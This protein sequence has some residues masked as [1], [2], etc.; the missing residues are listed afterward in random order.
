MPVRFGESL[1]SVVLQVWDTRVKA[2]VHNF[3]NTYQVTAVCF[4]D[5][6]EHVFSGGIDNDIKVWD[7]RMGASFHICFTWISCSPLQ[8]LEYRLPGHADT[9]TGLALS[10]DGAYL[11]SNSMDCSGKRLLCVVALKMHLL[12]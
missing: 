11:L 5:T 12:Q 9:V 7:L 2:H 1:F 3:Q 10:A 8:N 6:A 4:D